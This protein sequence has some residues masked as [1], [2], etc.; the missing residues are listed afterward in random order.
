MSDCLNTN[1]VLCCSGVWPG[2]AECTTCC[3]VSS[4]D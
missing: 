2:P 1:R 3:A 4:F